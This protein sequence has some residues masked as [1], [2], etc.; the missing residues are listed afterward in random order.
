MTEPAGPSDPRSKTILIVDD[1]E[2]VSAYFEMLLSREGFKL[3]VAN[4]GKAALE[5]LKSK[6]YG[7]IDLVFLDLMMPAPGGYE[8][9]KELQS[10]DYQRVSIFVVTART[11]DPG[12]VNM[13]KLESNV[14]EF[15]AKPIYSTELLEKVHRHLGTVPKTNQ[16]G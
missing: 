10:P 4:S 13:L 1:D 16:A 15:C 2:T 9:L 3:A 7:K 6:A 11:L 14:L 5:K 8:V 12:T